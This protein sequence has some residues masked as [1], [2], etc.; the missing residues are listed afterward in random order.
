[1]DRWTMRELKETD[2]IT[3]A[4][5]ILYERRKGLTPYSPLGMK[6]S[7]AAHTLSEIKAERDRYLERLSAVCAT[8]EAADGQETEAEVLEDITD[9]TGCD[10]ATKLEILDNAKKLEEM[11]CDPCEPTSPECDACEFGGAE[12]A[13]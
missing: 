7:E 4:I 3:F 10:E 11:Q 1:M 2:D 9:L 8:Q 5:Q 13:V 6:L 12:D